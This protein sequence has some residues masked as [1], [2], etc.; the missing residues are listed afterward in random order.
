ML[1][2][3]ASL[4]E[5]FILLIGTMTLLVPHNKSFQHFIVAHRFARSAP[6]NSVKLSV[7][8]QDDSIIKMTPS[9]APLRV[10]RG[11]LAAL[12]NPLI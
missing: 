10:A 4:D 11:V 5:F 12:R 3:L 2:A 9:S 7:F 1:R 8:L 6:L